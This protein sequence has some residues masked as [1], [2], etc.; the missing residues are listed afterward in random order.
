[1][2][3]ETRIPHPHRAVKSAPSR[4]AQVPQGLEAGWVP[5]AGALPVLALDQAVP[6][7]SRVRDQELLSAG[8]FPARLGTAAGT[9]GPGPRA[10]LRGLQA[11]LGLAWAAQS[12]VLPATPGIAPRVVGEG[13]R[14]GTRR[15]R[16]ASWK[17]RS[18]L[19]PCPLPPPLPGAGGVCASV[20][21]GPGLSGQASPS[22][23]PLPLLPSPPWSFPFP[24]R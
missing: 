11:W 20:Q 13:V 9:L 3:R 6:C 22:S 10:G 24:V 17:R 14:V 21:T 7:N 1:M 19:K 15:G 2:P 12:V 23:S 8:T 18:C 16:G 4:A 5:S